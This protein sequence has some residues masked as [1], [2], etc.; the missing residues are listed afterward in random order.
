MIIKILR[1]EIINLKKLLGP[2][3]YFNTVS[4]CHLGSLGV[5]IFKVCFSFPFPYVQPNV[6]NAY[7]DKNG[8]L[9][10]LNL[11]AGDAGAYIC[12]A[13]NAFGTANSVVT[14]VVHGNAHIR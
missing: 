13:S 1:F 5:E 8:D 9:V 11:Q 10:I 14:L 7:E 2:F 3:T 12:E 4:L 6:N